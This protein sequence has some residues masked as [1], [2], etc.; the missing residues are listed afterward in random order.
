MPYRASSYA[1]ALTPPSEFGSM[2]RVLEVRSVAHKAQP[3]WNCKHVI[4]SARKETMTRWS[5][6]QVAA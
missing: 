6:M 2:W 1:P 4:Q 5:R 3:T